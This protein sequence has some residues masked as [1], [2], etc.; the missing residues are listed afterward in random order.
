MGTAMQQG[1]AWGARAGDWSAVQE[2]KDLAA[3]EAVLDTCGPWREVRLLDVG[4][5]SGEFASLAEAG[6]ARVAGIDASPE[7]IEIAEHRVPDGA[8]RVGDMEHL[9]YADGSFE[10]VTGIN[11]FQYTAEPPDALAEAARVTRPGGRVVALVWGAA[12][13]CDAASYLQAI[14][15]MQPPEAAAPEPFALSTP[16]VLEELLA[17][18]GLTACERHMAP[19]TWFY[20][21]SAAA[22]R[23]LLSTGP[24]ATAIER[25]GEDAVKET[26]LESIR[27][28]RCRSGIYLL[29]NTFQ[30]LIG[31]R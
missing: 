20:S 22:L 31:T 8:F 7:L 11:S 2:W 17:R 23:G 13:E 19:C 24:A 27:S 1:A 3:Y 21:D 29:R 14:H 30:Y 28:F 15:A 6:G 16:G 9:P 10:I 4:C 12:D 26:V 5:G 25:L 18:A